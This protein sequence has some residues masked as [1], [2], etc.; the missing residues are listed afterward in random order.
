MGNP[1]LNSTSWLRNL[2]PANSDYYQNRIIDNAEV[3]SFETQI[4]QSELNNFLSQGL[5]IDSRRLLG[6]DRG[7]FDYVG[8]EILL[9]GDDSVSNTPVTLIFKTR[10]IE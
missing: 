3:S 9:N 2:E 7:D 6:L 5:G 4:R 1:N 8:V 10:E